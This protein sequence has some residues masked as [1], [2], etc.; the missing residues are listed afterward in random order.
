LEEDVIQLPPPASDD[1][2]VIRLFAFVEEVQAICD[3]Q[4]VE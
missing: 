3:T 1:D 2:C 4:C